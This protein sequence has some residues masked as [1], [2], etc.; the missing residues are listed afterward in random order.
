MKKVPHI[1]NPLSVSVRS[2][3]KNRLILDCRYLNDFITDKR[4]KYEDWRVALEYVEKGGFMF[5]W[6]LKSGY[7][8]IEMHPVYVKYLGFK[9]ELEGK[10]CYFVFL[11][12]AFGIKS[13]PRIFTKVIRPLIKHWRS[14]GIQVVG[15]LDDGWVFHKSREKCSFFSEKV[16][17]DLIQAGFVINK[18][19]SRWVPKPMVEWLGLIWDMSIGALIV[20]ERRVYSI[21]SDISHALK[22]EKLTAIFLAR[23]TGKII[24]MSPVLGNLTRIM[25]RYLYWAIN[26]RSG[27]ST[28]ISICDCLEVVEELQFWEKC[29]KHYNHYAC[30]LLLICILLACLNLSIFYLQYTAER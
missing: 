3:G 5:N 7:H 11:V 25:T 20:P 17:S 15:Y 1:V 23:I 24:S 29:R 4:C 14:G 28:Y 27:W 26:C 22:R 2:S 21:L 18:S 6:D 8:H 16:R 19:K 12:L 9:H 13:G 10:E 30:H